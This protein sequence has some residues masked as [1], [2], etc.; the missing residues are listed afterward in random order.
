[1]H[2]YDW[3]SNKQKSS[4]KTKPLSKGKGPVAGSVNSAALFVLT[5]IGVSMKKKVGYTN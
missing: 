4:I 2:N 3:V 5:I 1:M